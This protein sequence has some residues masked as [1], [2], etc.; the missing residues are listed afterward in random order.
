MSDS[1]LEAYLKNVKQLVPGKTEGF[2]SR[3]YI[4]NYDP[5]TDIWDVRR[6]ES[7]EYKYVMRYAIAVEPSCSASSFQERA[8]ND[9]G[10]IGK[11]KR[12]NSEVKTIERRTMIRHNF[13]LYKYEDGSMP[14]PQKKARAEKGLNKLT[15]GLR[16][17]RINTVPKDKRKQTSAEPPKRV[18]STES[19]SSSDDDDDMLTTF[20]DN[21]EE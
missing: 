12:S 14:R 2:D 18:E 16:K 5:F 21:D 9:C 11:G 10:E 15:L 19:I 6:I 8:F 17:I 3:Y 1:N 20:N 13:H 7:S 4:T